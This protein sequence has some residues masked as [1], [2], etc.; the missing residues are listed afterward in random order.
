MLSFRLCLLVIVAATADA[1]LPL[2]APLQR[3]QVVVQS[4]VMDAKFSDEIFDD[5]M[6]VTQMISKRASSGAR[7]TS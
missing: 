2:R 7:S 5:F 6:T 4:S 1:F 3:T